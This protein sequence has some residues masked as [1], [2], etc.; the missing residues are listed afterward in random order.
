MGYTATRV[1]TSTL[2]VGAIASAGAAIVH[3]AAA[4]IHADH[5]GL[6]RLFIVLAIAQ[7]AAAI[8]GF[9]RD[10][11][12]ACGTLAGV[13][14]VAS[15]GWLITRVTGVSSI[16]G[17]QAA[18][19][20]QPA[21]TVAAVLALVAVA[22]AVGCATGRAQVVTGRSLTTSAVIVGVLV[23]PGLADA[24]SHQHATTNDHGAHDEPAVHDE[25]DDE[26]D[27][28]GHDGD[29]DADHAD[30]HDADGH[31]ADALVEGGQPLLDLEG[32]DAPFGQVDPEGLDMHV[33]EL[34]THGLP[35]ACR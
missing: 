25:H 9:L 14:A 19:R 28:D 8:L 13:N 12:V 4:G 7:G 34:E 29:H 21:D 22:A 5:V 1:Q 18:E 35:P 2:T 23:V 27:A 26:H 3:G 30:G 20:P 33:V 32:G 17:L 10:D 11:R 24:T 16:S 6:S 15:A 31:E